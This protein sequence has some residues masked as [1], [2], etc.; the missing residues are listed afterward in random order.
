MLATKIIKKYT[1]VLFVSL[2]NEWSIYFVYL[3]IKVLFIFTQAS[4]DSINNPLIHRICLLQLLSLIHHLNKFSNVHSLWL[5]PKN[6]RKR[7]FLPL[8]PTLYTKQEPSKCR[9]SCLK[10][11]P[12]VKFQGLGSNIKLSKQYTKTMPNY[13]QATWVVTALFSPSWESI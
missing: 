9:Y 6:L 10:S 7:I 11:H 2:M 13:G 5:N 8:H 12:I 4:L 3:C 1:L